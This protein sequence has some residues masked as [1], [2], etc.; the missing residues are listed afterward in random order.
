ML[1]NIRRNVEISVVPMGLTMVLPC[2]NWFI[3]GYLSIEE[4]IISRVG[5][6][7]F[8]ANERFLRNAIRKKGVVPYSDW[9][10]IKIRS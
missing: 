2:K 5:W 10:A 8:V 6:Q 4:F 1:T 3:R 9:Q 7:S